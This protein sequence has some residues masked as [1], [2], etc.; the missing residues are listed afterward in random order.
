MQ[1]QNGTIIFKLATMDQGKKIDVSL[2]NQNLKCLIFIYSGNM[3]GEAPYAIGAGC[4]NLCN[5][6]K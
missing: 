5:P 6:S 4:E 2:K 1:Q 3:Q